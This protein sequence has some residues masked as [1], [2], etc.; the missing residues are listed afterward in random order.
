M[1]TNHIKDRHGSGKPVEFWVFW[2]ILIVAVVIRL[3]GFGRIPYGVNQDEA[4]GAVDG[5]ALAQYGTDRFGVRLP[6]HFSAWQVSQMSVLLSYLMI[7]VIKLF[8]FST[9][10]IR[11]PILL[12]SIGG[13]VLMYLI[14]KHLF[15]RR[16]G[17][18]AMALTAINPWH[19]M[20]SRWSLDCNLFPHV[21]LLGFFLLLLAV[22]KSVQQK[23]G[24]SA[25]KERPTSGAPE[26]RLVCKATE[27]GSASRATV[28]TQTSKATAQKQ[29]KNPTAAAHAR[30]TLGKRLLLLASMVVFGLTFYCYGIA[31]YSVT[32]FLVVYAIC[33]LKKKVFSWG[34]I[35]ASMV[36]FLVVA[37]PE[38]LVMAINMFHWQT[39][40]TGWI[41]MSRFPESVRGN[42]ILFLNFS[43]AQLGK[44]ILAMVKTCFVQT[45]DYW[46]NT[47]PWFGPLY[48]ISIPFMCAG[49]VILTYRLFQGNRSQSTKAPGYA[50]PEN[51]LLEQF[52]RL[53]IWGFLL[54]GIWV[55]LITYEVNVNRINI[56]FYPL[57]LVTAYAIGLFVDKCKKAGP[58]IGA[59]FGICGILFLGSYFTIY[60]EKVAV[61][62]NGEFLEAV[63]R[64]DETTK[65]LYI[66][67]NMGW[68]FNLS[69][70]EI[71]TQYACKTDALY[72]QGKTNQTGGR[73]LA[74]YA[75]RYH[76]INAEI[77]DWENADP[78][79][80][81]LLQEG[82]LDKLSVD[83]QVCE[84][85]GQFIILEIEKD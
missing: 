75:D 51:K 61:Y 64:A 5:W 83:Y 49:T 74:L 21:F 47:I 41:T 32:A 80:V 66:T 59:L 33:C 15:S 84:E 20:Q 46:F 72:F 34:E 3:V 82:E 73:T 30:K 24:S 70:A 85:I 6:V 40:D 77:Y 55:G 68:Q 60:P 16:I 56:I 65:P 42:D 17:L 8:G 13:I 43:F 81:Y 12:A 50:I 67:G 54:T 48:H 38:I 35:L 4:M 28:A 22:E 37:L 58:V 69:M 19:F 52:K 78:D 62:Y 57:I 10:V 27:E 63:Q 44:N 1:N 53:A 79:G 29:D 31:V 18:I 23:I 7:P 45:P 25:P 71:L 36:V 11:I 9:T 14:G 39:I 76:F 2:G 26:E